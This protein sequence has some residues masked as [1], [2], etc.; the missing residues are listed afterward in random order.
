MPC[1]RAMHGHRTAMAQNVTT[2]NKEREAHVPERKSGEAI[3][4]VIVGDADAS[5]DDINVDT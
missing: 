4:Y 5:V 2:K 3:P 1:I